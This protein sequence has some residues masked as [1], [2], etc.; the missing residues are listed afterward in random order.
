[1]EAALV[2]AALMFVRDAEE[3]DERPPAPMLQRHRRKRR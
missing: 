2:E 3:G 1:M